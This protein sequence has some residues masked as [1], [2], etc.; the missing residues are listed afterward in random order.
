MGR[1]VDKIV[2]CLLTAAAIIVIITLQFFGWF[3]WLMAGLFVFGSI[4]VGY[5]GVL[6]AMYPDRFFN[7]PWDSIPSPKKRAL[8][9]IGLFS[10]MTVLYVTSVLVALNILSLSFSGE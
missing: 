5:L 7:Q 6:V 1:V 3:K 9:S 10:I 2:G 4:I 8:I